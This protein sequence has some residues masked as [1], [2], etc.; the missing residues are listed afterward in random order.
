[1]SDSVALQFGISGQTLLSV[2]NQTRLFFQSTGFS[3]D[4]C[5]VNDDDC[6]HNLCQ[7]GATCLDGVG[8]YEC[9]CLPEFTGRF[10]SEDVDEC[11]VYQGICQNGATCANTH[12]GYQCIC[13][14]GYEGN[15]CEKDK[16][17][18]ATQPCLYGGTC[19]DRVA[20][21][22]CEC[23]PGRTGLLCHL[24]DAC[25]SNP[26]NA[27]AICETDVVSGKYNCSCPKGFVGPD[28]N[29]DINECDEGKEHRT[30]SLS[31]FFLSIEHLRPQALGATLE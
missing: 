19:H 28:C 10:C 2:L 17:D 24:E 26:C 5:E 13:V 25:A 4:R 8:S 27:G 31:P 12:D 11:A 20:N 3:G 21:Y 7:N 29:V 22:Y 1:M 23:P 15:N 30:H 18:C 9:Q 16:D 14:N 6:G